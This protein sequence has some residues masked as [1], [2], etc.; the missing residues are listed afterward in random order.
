MVICLI[1]LQFCPM[2]LVLGVPHCPDEAISVLISMSANDTPAG[3]LQCTSS[4][5]EAATLARI[6]P[7]VMHSLADMLRPVP[8]TPMPSRGAPVYRALHAATTLEAVIGCLGPNLPQTDG[9]HAMVLQRVRASIAA[10]TTF[11]GDAAGDAVQTASQGAEDEVQ[12][13]M[14]CAAI[15][16]ATTH[17]HMS[18][19]GATSLPWQAAADAADLAP[20]MDELEA[21][22]AEQPEDTV[23]R[24]GLQ[25]A[26]GVAG[27]VASSM[28][29]VCTSNMAGME[30]SAPN[31]TDL[32]PP[33]A[34]NKHSGTELE[35]LEELLGM[36]GGTRDAAERAGP[37]AADA[38]MFDAADDMDRD[39]PNDIEQYGGGAAQACALAELDPFQAQDQEVGGQHQCCRSALKTEPS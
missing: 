9:E 29:D 12:A 35:L 25:E 28:P 20:A 4:Q 21:G 34:S 26:A 5:V 10:I 18:G 6:T 2:I 8:A 33:L 19:D 31:P 11:I 7:S 24:I 32:Q 36:G 15:Q 30:L 39:M 1:H 13:M 14:M 17:P 16:N 3:A 38:T 23:H 27:D 37:G 22:A